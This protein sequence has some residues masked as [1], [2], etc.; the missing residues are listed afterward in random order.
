MKFTRVIRLH[1]GVCLSHA[2]LSNTIARFSVMSADDVIMVFSSLYWLTGVIFLIGGT[3]IGAK[4]I[5]TTQPSTPELQ[6]R[7]IEKYK[8][9]YLMNS[10]FQTTL[11][12]KHDSIQTTNLSSLKYYFTGGSRIPQDIPMLITKHLRNGKVHVAYGLSEI[13]GVA[14]ADFPV[15]RGLD[16]AGQLINGMQAKIVDDNGN[17]LGP[18]QNGEVCL[19]GS[20]KFLG[21]YRN[22]TAT[23]DLFDAEGF[24]LTGDIA[25]FDDTGYLYI[26]DRKREMLKYRGCQ[27]AP[28]YIESH[29][30]K[31]PLIKSVCVVG[32]P[33]DD[34][35]DLVAAA[36]IRNPGAKITEETVHKMID[37]NFYFFL[38]ISVGFLHK[39]AI[40]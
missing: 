38:T 26:V 14:S 27:L 22:K 19:K 2:A 39:F 40:S 21:Y 24:L 13:G 6:F 17:R 29:L 3:L 7:M 37:G 12:A 11:F 1:I 5:I 31:S 34:D 15:P 35:G 9:T 10:P 32:I 4:R 25:H 8:V 16:T 33:H 28:S 18:G 36:I 23:D 30:M 20:H